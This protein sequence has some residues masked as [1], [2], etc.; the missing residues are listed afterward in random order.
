[1]KSLLLSLSLL[2]G[3]SVVGQETQTS[4]HAHGVTQRGDQAMGF[5]HEKTS[6]HFRLFKD[7]GAIEVTANDPGDKESRDMIRMHLAHIAKMFAEGNFQAPMF[8]HDTDPPGA[9]VMAEL[10]GDIKYEFQEVDGGGRVKITTAN[11]KGIEA[12][13]SFLKFQIE[14]HQTGDPTD[15][16]HK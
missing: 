6:H 16:T 4:D 3:I 7:G 11:P 13:H 1:M 5:S 14:E 8:I 15:V 12:V 9:R 10:R 2:I